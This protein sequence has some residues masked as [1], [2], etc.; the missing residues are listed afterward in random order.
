[1]NPY[2]HLIIHWLLFYGVHSAMASTR[3]KDWVSQHAKGSV[4]YYRFMYNGVSLLLFFMAVWVQTEIE[5]ERWYSSQVLFILG[6]VLMILGLVMAYLSFRNYQMSEFLGLMQW[7]NKTFNAAISEELKING[8]NQLMRHPLYT[9]SYLL[10]FG[11]LM[12]KP[13]WGSFIFSFI[14][15]VYL[16][17]GARWEEKK[18]LKQFGSAYQNYQMNVPMFWPRIF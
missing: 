9:A 4:P 13:C 7:R 2:L 6:L 18:L 10:L 17:V 12:Y 1:M 8:L 5:E 11:Y 3:A 16:Y 14:G 15:C